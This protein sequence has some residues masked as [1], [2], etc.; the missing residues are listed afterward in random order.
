MNRIPNW[1]GGGNFLYK[2]IYCIAAP[3]RYGGSKEK[4]AIEFEK[5]I[6]IGP[7]FIVNRWGRAKYLSSITNNKELYVS[8]LNWVL[9]QDP[10]ACGNPHAWNIYFQDQARLM[11]A[12]TDRIFN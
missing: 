8:D 5:A 2:A 7:N 11:L 9:A 12:E 1:E 3:R 10:S 6:K 4:A